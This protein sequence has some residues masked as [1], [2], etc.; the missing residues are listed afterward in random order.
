MHHF[1]RREID[2]ND[3]SFVEKAIGNGAGASIRSGCLP[4]DA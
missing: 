2:E 3:F 1:R 4:K